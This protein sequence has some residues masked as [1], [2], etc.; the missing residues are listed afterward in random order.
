MIKRSQDDDFIIF[1]PDTLW[2]KNYADEINEMQDFYYSNRLSNI[3]LLT[4]KKLSFDKSLNGDFNLTRNL[5]KKEKF[6]EFIYVGC[7]I[8][9]RKLFEKYKIN[10]FPISEIW[11]ELLK[12]NELNGFKSSNK[13]YHLTNFETFK[14]LQDL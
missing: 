5:I 9:N 1:N 4:N 12:K 11:N 14:R 6:N 3:L 10:N 2:H 13:F 8:L 7:Q